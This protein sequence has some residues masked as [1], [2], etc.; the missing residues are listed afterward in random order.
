MAHHGEREA[1]D[2]PQRKADKTSPRCVSWP[3]KAQGSV[4]RVAGFSEA[5]LLVGVHLAV[6][7][8]SQQPSLGVGSGRWAGLLPS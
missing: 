6:T 3:P 2:W 1:S 8:T 4:S 5:Q 7:Q